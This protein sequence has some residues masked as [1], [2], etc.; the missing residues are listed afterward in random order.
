MGTKKAFIDMQPSGNMSYVRGFNGALQFVQG[1]GTIALR[2]EAGKQDLVLYV[3]GMQANMISAGQLKDSGVRVEHEGDEMLLVLAA[4]DV[5][6]RA[7][8]IG[9]VHCTNLLPC[10]TKPMLVSTEVVALR[11][12]TLPYMWDAR[13]ALVGDDTIKSSGKHEVATSLDIKPSAG[14]DLPCASCLG[15]KLVRHTFHDKGSNANE[16]LD[17]VQIDMCGPFW[18]TAKDDSLHVL[19]MKVRRLMHSNVKMDGNVCW[20][21]KEVI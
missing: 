6:G 3:P 17:V 9:R 11:T 7:K 19:L 15:G 18:V 2:G 21:W 8:H 12:I 14:A 20:N 16:A 4:G 1:R 10:S 13:L 5:L